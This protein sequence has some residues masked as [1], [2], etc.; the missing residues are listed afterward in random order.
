VQSPPRW[1]TAAIYEYAITVH[2]N[3]GQAM[4]ANTIFR[5]ITRV[6]EKTTYQDTPLNG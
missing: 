5:A 3:L 4:K 6:I 1:N 2:S